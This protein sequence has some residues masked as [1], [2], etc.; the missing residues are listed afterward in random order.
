M[1]VLTPKRVVL[2]VVAVL[3]GTGA[4]ASYPSPR[5][6]ARMAYDT[7][8][9][10]GVLFG[11]RGPF[12]GA[13]SLAHN[14]SETWLW[15]GATWVQQFPLHQPSPRGAHTMTYDSLHGRVYLFGGR[16]E[17]DDRDGDPTYLNDLW[18]WKDGDW[19]KVETATGPS[20]RH[21]SGLAFDR[22]RDRLVLFGGN[23]YAADGTTLEAKFDT[24]EFDGTNWTQVATDTP[25]VAKP[26]LVY[27]A[28]AKQIIMMGVNETGLA[29]V[30]YRYD[31]AAHAWVQMTPPALPT[32]VN[33]GHLFY[34][35]HNGRLLFM[36][37]VC[38]TGTPN[39]EELFEW[40]GTTWTKITTNNTIG[41]AVGQAVA[42]ET[43]RQRI[44]SFGGTSVFDNI[45]VS[46]T[47]TLENGRW[48]IGYSNTRPFPRS[49]SAFTGDT[50][51]SAIWLFGGLDDTSSAYFGDFWG[52]RNGQWFITNIPNGPGAGCETPLSSW[53]SDRSRLVVTCSG[54][55]VFEFD[56]AAWK[57]FTELKKSPNARNYARMVYDRKLKKTVLFGGYATGNYRNDTWTWNGTEWSEVSVSGDKPEHRGLFA[58]WY[59]PLQ[60]KTILYGGFGRPHVNEK[61]T[62]YA[63]MWAFDG[64]RWTKLNPAQTP[65]PRFGPQ[66]AVHPTTGRVLLFGGLRSEEVDEDSIRQYFDN[67]TWQ[68]DGSAGTWTKLQ[69]QRVPPAREN[70]MLAWDPVANEMVLFGGYA[71]GFYFSDLWIWN[72]ENWT[73]RLENTVRRRSAGR[74]GN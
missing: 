50:A 34:Q 11:G 62:R 5:T 7:Q 49:L 22:D 73:P 36:G 39:L 38:P 17:A 59:D 54:A 55:Q 71:N 45:L 56:G 35:E 74:G 40:N 27:D 67:D 65:G 3:L 60:Q 72:G 10:V 25:K 8:N 70:G 57:T 30:M 58:M 18:Y 68:W 21:F 20:A 53:D 64:S 33:E 37:G 24:W 29:N 1:S 52:Y 23:G 19:T 13:T 28:T 4:Y 69:P 48:A 46:S 31:G 15:S 47:T 9:K 51:S 32:C 61:V 26:L 12:D 6:L 42:F 16:K 14:T 63:D 66:V 2:F 44:I 43:L 41:R